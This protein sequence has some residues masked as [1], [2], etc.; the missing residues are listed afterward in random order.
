MKI[1]YKPTLS[2]FEVQS[3]LY[4][5]LKYMGINVRGNVPNARK[6]DRGSTKRMIFDLVIFDKE[7][8]PIEIIEVKDSKRHKLNTYQHKKYKSTGIKVTYV[9][10][11]REA[12]RYISKKGGG[13][14]PVIHPKKRLASVV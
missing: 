10:G 1:P 14:N 8:K 13:C 2:E 3:F 7:N 9:R 6:R 12:K 11:M 5:S 4:T